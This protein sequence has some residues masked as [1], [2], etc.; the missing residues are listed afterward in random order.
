MRSLAIALL[1]LGLVVNHFMQ[2]PPAPQFAPDLQGAPAARA[3]APTTASGPTST[4]SPSTA[5][6][7]TT[8]LGWM[9]G[10]GAGRGWKSSATRM[11]PR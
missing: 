5:S 8:A 10:L 2:R 6:A 4:P 11:K 1:L 3:P 7:A 9:P